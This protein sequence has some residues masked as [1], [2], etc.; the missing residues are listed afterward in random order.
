[1]NSLFLQS[2]RYV[3]GVLV[4]F[5]ISASTLRAQEDEKDV[6][7]VPTPK[8][9]VEKML[10]LADVQKGDYLIDLGSGDGRIVIQAARQGADGHGVDIDP[11][12]VSEARNNAQRA[13]VDDQVS[14]LKQDLFKTDVSKASVVTIYLLPSINLK[15]RDRL[16]DELEPGTKLVSHR[17]DMDDWEPDKQVTVETDKDA[18]GFLFDKTPTMTLQHKAHEVYYWVI[19]AQVQGSWQWETHGHS[20]KMQVEQHFQ[21]VHIELTKDGNEMQIENSVLHGKRLRFG[22]ESRETEYVFNGRVDGNEIKGYLQ[23]RGE[24]HDRVVPWKAVR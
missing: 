12:K 11:S 22:A 16:I 21:E 17:F 1:M 5:L 19:P 8:P 2:Q 3:L 13:G 9:V 10:E 14:F 24:Q 6:P 4:L 23:V 15:I 18:P 7:Y 20:F